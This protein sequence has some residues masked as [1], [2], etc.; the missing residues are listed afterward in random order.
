[1]PWDV[2]WSRTSG[3]VV[4]A[5]LR[6]VIVESLKGDTSVASDAAS[7]MGLAAGQLVQE[8]GWDEDVDDALRIEIED[9]VDGELVEDAVEAVD[10]VLL[11]WREDDGDLADGLVDA[12][13]DLRDDGVVWLLTPKVGR[14]GHVEP[15]DI[16]EAALTAGLAQTSTSNLSSDWSASKLVR[17]RGTR[18]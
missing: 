3:N 5:H 2:T 15:A 13:T 18:R 12:L 17:P 16:A 6:C 14:D 7:R 8:L 10:V 4:S 1:M 11:W 9:A